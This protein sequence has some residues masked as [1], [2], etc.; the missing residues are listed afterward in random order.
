MPTSPSDKWYITQQTFPQLLHRNI[1]HFGHRKA[2]W[3]QE[4][5]PGE[6]QSL[7]YSELGV[8]IQ[9]LS[10]GLLSLGIKKGDRVGVM[11]ST[12]PQWMQADYAILCAGGIT[13]CLYPSLSAGE[14]TFMV[15]DSGT[16]VLFLQN[17]AMLDKVRDVRDQM[18]GLRRIILM[19]GEAPD[20]G[21][22]LSMDHLRKRGG[23]SHQTDPDAWEDRWQSV[24]LHDPMTIVYTSGTTGK[25]KGVVH[26]HFS[27][28]AACRRDLSAIPVL[29]EADLLLSFLPLSHTY[30]RECGHGIAMHAAIPIAYASPKTLLTALPL[31]QPTL[32]M[33]VPRIY[34]RIYMGMKAQAS[35][36]PIKQRLF[37]A[38][39]ATGMA[40]VEAR[41]DADGFINMSEEADLLS[42]AGPF[43]SLKYKL[44]DRLIFSKVRKRLGGR[45]RFAFSAAGSLSADLCK[46]FMAMGVRIFE[47]YG[48]TETCNA[49]NLNAPEAILPGS[50]G[51][52]CHGVTC[53]MAS[54]GEW[55]VKGDSLFVGYWNNEEASKAAFTEDGFYKTGDI[56]EA[57]AGDHIRIVDRKN[58]LLVLDTGKNVP[59]SKVEGLFALSPF[60]DMV[61]AVGSGEKF[62]T[63]IVFP[64][65]DLVLAELKAT[66]IPVEGYP[67]SHA[68]GI[69]V[70]V[71]PDMLGH[72][73]VIRLIQQEIT[74][75]NAE[76][77]P[78]E[79]IKKFHISHRKL[80]EDDG[81]LTPTFKVKRKVVMEHYGH[82]IEGLYLQ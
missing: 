72:P 43:L 35:T 28:N 82:E 20:K 58:G 18:P 1:T 52:P 24:G 80:T 67:L 2:Q 63:A 12:S 21:V 27:I 33:S 11:G 74:S 23:I 71:S 16:S 13:V 48:S 62:I 7:S 66:G 25:P 56:V 53:R 73:E 70:E 57:V 42:G 31:F 76:L 40:V 8:V 64:D 59:S 3:W 34:E 14:L 55:Q 65:F 49:I 54:D 39:M 69:C 46:T 51:A 79:Q 77:E 6:T 5:S 45:F 81:E 22:A 47:G 19:E 41:S 17:A 4:G 61:V 75:A 32:F 26:S 9:E 38:A 78:Y 30:E 60:V 15:N 37:N 36:S 10:E 44:F 68:D 29:T 50:V